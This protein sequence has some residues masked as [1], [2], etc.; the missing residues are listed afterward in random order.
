MATSATKKNKRT[1]LLCFL[2][3]VLLLAIVP[4]IIRVAYFPVDTGT[5]SLLGETNQTD[6]FSQ[7]KAWVLMGFSVL[8]LVL[9][10]IFC[11]TLFRRMGR[12]QWFYLGGAAIF[13]LFTLLSALFSNN[14]EVAFGGMYD[15]A[16]GFFTLT[17]YLVIF[18]YTLYAFQE[19]GW[20]GFIL[21]ALT[22]VTL[23][24]LFLGVFQYIGKDLINTEWMQ[25]LVLPSRYRDRFGG[26]SLLYEKGKLYGTLFH[27]NYVGSLTAMTI[28]LFFI[29]GMAVKKIWEKILLFFLAVCSLF[30]LFGSTSRAGIIGLAAAVLFGLLFFGRSLLERW[31]L[32]LAAAGGV[33]VIIVGLNAVTQG[34]IFERLPALAKDLV[35]VWEDTSD[36][37]YLDELPIRDVRAQG[38]GIAVVLQNGKIMLSTDGETLILK[39]EHGELLPYEQNGNLYSSTDPRYEPFQFRQFYS[40]EESS[41]FDTVLLT[42]G[43]QA[44]FRFN[45]HYNMSELEYTMTMCSP[46]VDLEIEL[47]EPEVTRFFKGKERLGS[48]RGYIWGRTI[49]LLRDYLLLGAGPDNFPFEFPQHDYLGKWWAYG[50]TNMVVDK[51]HNLYLQI[52]MNEGGIALLAF[53]VMAGAYL[54]DSIRLYA[55]RKGHTLPEILGIANCLAIIGYLFAGFFN[56]SVVSVA[57]IFWILFGAGVALN[58]LNR[59]TSSAA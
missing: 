16:E 41:F 3:V 6:L 30:L 15:R 48:M 40:S 17:C 59:K 54:V 14:P 12:W 21:L 42:V 7:W 33:A 5:Y 22:V 13:W 57:P 1:A 39:N 58:G 44:R 36:F 53:L 9:A 29:A 49:P 26:M 56:D 23:V 47:D 37:N 24:N 32:L 25:H 27:Y 28:P 18:L 52:F 35:R 45:V 8:L 10:V 4:L 11:K 19:T 34:S 38:K 46:Y 50:T 43:N 20:Y 31:K 51:P 55:W 2:P